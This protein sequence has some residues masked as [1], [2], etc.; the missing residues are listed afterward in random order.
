MRSSV[1]QHFMSSF[2]LDFLSPKKISLNFN[3][4]RL[5]VWLSY[6]KAARKILVKSAP[7]LVE[8]GAILL[9]KLNDSFG[10]VSNCTC[11]KH[12]LPKSWEIDPKLL[13]LT[14]LLV[15]FETFFPLFGMS[16]SRL[17][18]LLKQLSRNLK[19]FLWETFKIFT[20]FFWSG[21]IL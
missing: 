17:P 13:P 14:S 4:E 7:S 6:E 3:T 20:L 2:S 12:L 15:T 18:A 19:L 5:L 16:G 21:T 9:V 11:L 8:F 1:Y 10:F